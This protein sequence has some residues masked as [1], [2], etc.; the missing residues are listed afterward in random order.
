M[1]MGSEQYIIDIVHIYSIGYF[2][3]HASGP[4]MLDGQ[5]DLMMY[6]MV[7]AYLSWFILLNFF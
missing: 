6:T 1:Y 4:S 3:L 2:A 7:V 5:S